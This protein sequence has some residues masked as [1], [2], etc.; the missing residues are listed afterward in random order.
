MTAKPADAAA[1]VE[2]WHALIRAQQDYAKA[3]ATLDALVFDKTD[4]TSLMIE[5]RFEEA[6]QVRRVAYARYQEAMGQLSDFFRN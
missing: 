2:L 1:E 3:L 5:G 6:A 4:T